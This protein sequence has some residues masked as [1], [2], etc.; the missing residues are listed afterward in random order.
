MIKTIKKQVAF[1][2]SE[3][4]AMD[5]RGKISAIQS[6]ILAL[7]QKS[8]ELLKQLVN[9]IVPREVSVIVETK[10]DTE[11]EYYDGQV[12]SVRKIERPKL[13]VVEVPH[14]DLGPSQIVQTPPTQE[15]PFISVNPTVLEEHQEFALD[16][17]IDPDFSLI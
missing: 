9:N 7:S 13:E 3:Q 11:T 6:E 14:N 17:V 8:E 10:G 5:L 16:E 2:L 1:R 4:E 15:P 12:I